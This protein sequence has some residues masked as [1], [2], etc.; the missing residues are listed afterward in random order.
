MWC[1]LISLNSEDFICIQAVNLTEIGS[2]VVLV[3]QLNSNDF[4][5]IQ[6]VKRTEILS[7]VVLVHQLNAEDFNCIQSEKTYRNRI[8][9]GACSSAEF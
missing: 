3:H 6:A 8:T 5:S 2:N 7:H 9:F 1:L 4:N